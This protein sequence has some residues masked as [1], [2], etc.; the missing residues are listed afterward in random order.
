[1]V[2][3]C[4]LRR[5]ATSVSCCAL[6]GSRMSLSFVAVPPGVAILTRLPVDVSAMAPPSSMTCTLLHLS[7]AMER[8]IATACVKFHSIVPILAESFGAR[9][10]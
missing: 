3:M 10:T 4:R 6:I 1:M 8:I 5:R 9:E 7:A 2:T